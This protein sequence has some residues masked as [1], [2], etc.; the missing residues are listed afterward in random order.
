SRR[1]QADDNTHPTVPAAGTSRD[2]PAGAG[3]EISGGMF[4]TVQD[5]LVE[6]QEAWGIVTHDFPDTDMTANCEGGIN[7]GGVCLFEAKGNLITGNT[8]Q[9]NGSFGNPTNGDLA[10]ESSSTPRNCFS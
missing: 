5:N 9:N 8:L 10:N 2:A 7:S 6:N 3:I 1:D 4:D